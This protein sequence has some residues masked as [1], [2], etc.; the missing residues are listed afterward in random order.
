MVY[1]TGKRAL[2]KRIADMDF[3]VVTV[4]CEAMID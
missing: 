2:A 1:E 3:D 4:F